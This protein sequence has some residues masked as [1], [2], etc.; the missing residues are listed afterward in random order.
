M[1]ATERLVLRRPGP[2]DLSAFLRIYGDPAT[3]VHDPLGP[4]P[5]V[6]TAAT[7]LCASMAHWEQHGFGSF[8]VSTLDA[9]RWVI[10][11]AGVAW[12]EYSDAKVLNLGYRLEPAAWGKGYATELAAESLENAFD[13]LGLRQVFA[14]VRPAN[15]AS[16]RVLEKIGMERV[17]RLD[18]VPG[19][20]HSVVYRAACPL[21]D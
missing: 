17:G 1:L 3:N 8:V 5:D 14:L 2:E 16:I 9:P 10:G 13:R 4:A 15:A 11:F 19:Q 7:L 6:A 21:L 18:D 20:E 12:R